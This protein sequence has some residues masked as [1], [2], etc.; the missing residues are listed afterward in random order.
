MRTPSAQPGAARRVL[1]VDHEDSFVHTLANFLRQTGASVET[2]RPEPARR[3]L[4]EEAPDLVVLSPG[5]GRPEDFGTA[6][7]IALV[8][9]K[10][11][12]AVR[13]LLRPAGRGRVLR[14]PSRPARRA[15]STASP[16][17]SRC[18]AAHSSQGLPA[19]FRVGRYHSLYARRASLPD[20]LL[21]V[22]A[23]TDDG[24]VMALEHRAK[25]IAAV[26]FHPESILSL[27]EGIGMRLIDN[28]VTVLIG[29]RGPA[30]G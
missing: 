13:R 11:V 21:A 28:M 4:Q 19:R 24:V 12:P 25:P 30:G 9:A 6:E 10:D 1:L 23:E 27:D 16:P 26:Q 14:R 8:L 17:R 3:M 7:T 2:L 5:P 22:T 18:R 15:R 20:D 29:N